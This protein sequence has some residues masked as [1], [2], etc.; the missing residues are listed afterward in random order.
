M[1]KAYEEANY[2]ILDDLEDFEATT[3]TWKVVN[4]L[5]DMEP[6]QQTQQLM[7]WLGALHRE[8]CRLAEQVDALRT[9]SGSE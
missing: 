3:E 4:K 7:L 8:V 2:R 6:T 1:G 9:S 5:R